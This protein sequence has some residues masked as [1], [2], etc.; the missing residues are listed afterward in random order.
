MTKSLFVMTALKFLEESAVK[1]VEKYGSK[2]NGNA[3]NKVWRKV[4]SD[5][6]STGFWATNKVSMYS[7]KDGSVAYV[8]ENMPNWQNIL[9]NYIDLAQK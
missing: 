6:R 5:A 1:L 2:V 8:Q 3:F 7:N 9:K 4:D